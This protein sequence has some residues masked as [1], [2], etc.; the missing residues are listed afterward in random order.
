MIGYIMARQAQ[1]NERIARL[2]IHEY[3]DTGHTVQSLAHELNV[4]SL[5]KIREEF[6]RD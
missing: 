5:K 3:R 1:A 4:K 6:N 2:M